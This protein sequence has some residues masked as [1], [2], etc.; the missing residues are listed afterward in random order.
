[1]QGFYNQNMNQNVQSNNNNNYQQGS[2]IELN[3]YINN[4]SIFYLSSSN[5][6][7]NAE[8]LNDEG[9]Y[10]SSHDIYGFSNNFNNNDSPKEEG[11][12]YGSIFSGNINLTS[13]NINDNTN[14]N[15]VQNNPPQNIFNP[16]PNNMNTFPFNYGQNFQPGI[17]NYNFNNNQGIINPQNEIINQN[18]QSQ[19]IDIQQL[20]KKMF[21][22]FP[23]Q[24]IK[25]DNKQIASHKNLE[26]KLSFLGQ[27][28]VKKPNNTENIVKKDNKNSEE[29]II[30]NNINAGNNQENIN[31]EKDLPQNQLNNVENTK[32]NSIDEN[33]KNFNLDDIPETKTN[34]INPDNNNIN[35]DNL[36]EI[37]EIQEIETYVEDNENKNNS[38]SINEKNNDK[39]NDIFSNFQEIE[40]IHT[41]VQ[42]K[43]NYSNNNS[44]KTNSNNNSTRN[45][46]EKNNIGGSG[47]SQL[48]EKDGESLVNSNIKEKS[49]INNEENK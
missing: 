38:N 48:Y 22:N 21:N 3:T 29:N 30:N 5:N 4:G 45:N 40:E 37:E 24:T 44:I 42:S 11:F 15:F 7:L 27:K 16:Q 47:I 41:E 34:I 18:L 46:T 26:L 32:I 25:E 6:C 9:S 20:S 10:I 14:Q 8:K 12:S 43:F 33:I 13:N 2:N 23:E 36:E 35:E 17:G 39:D 49:E 28:K 1:M 31:K 19:Q